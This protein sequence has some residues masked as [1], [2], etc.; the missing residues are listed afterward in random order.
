MKM[1]DVVCTFDG[2]C[3]RE[4]ERWWDGRGEREGDGELAWW[5]RIER[6]G[7]GEDVG[8]ERERE[9]GWPKMRVCGR[10]GLFHY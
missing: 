1:G 8:R 7:D 2:V 10:E 6:K 9:R 4:R 5:K 3:V